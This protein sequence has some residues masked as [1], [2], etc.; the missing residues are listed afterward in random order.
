MPGLG[1]VDLVLSFM[2]SG[3][4]VVLLVVSGLS[5][6]RGRNADDPLDPP[7]QPES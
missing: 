4:L 5:I 6:W 2:Y 7:R 1:E 3:L